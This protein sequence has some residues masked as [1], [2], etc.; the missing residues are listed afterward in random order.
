MRT[1]QPY[2]TDLYYSEILQAHTMNYSSPI[3]DE[4]G[5]IIGVLSTR[6]NWA[7]VVDIINRANLG[8]NSLLYIVNKN[9]VIIASSDE[10]DYLKKDLNSY[11]TVQN[12]I[13]RS[14]VVGYELEQNQIVAYHRSQG[15]NNYEGKGWYAIVIEKISS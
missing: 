5:Q 4:E 10:K 3:H 2:V 7:Y 6:F 8:M 1:N 9:G 12:A 15:Y 13:R 11:E 14:S